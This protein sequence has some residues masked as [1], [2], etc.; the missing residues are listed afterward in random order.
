MILEQQNKSGG[1][2]TSELDSSGFL[3]DMG[4]HVVFSHYPY[5]DHVLSEA[6]KGW[7]EHK[8]AAFAFMMGSSGKR[9]FVPYPVQDNV[10]TLDEEERV[11]VRI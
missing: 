6:V 8:R 3:W 7:N 5:F 11:K 10:L 1:L 2:A 9:S 4:G